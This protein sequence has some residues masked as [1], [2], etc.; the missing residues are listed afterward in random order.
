MQLH[1]ASNGQI[2]NINAMPQGIQRFIWYYYTV[3]LQ[4]KGHTKNYN[5]VT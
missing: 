4:V 2:N 5:I 3:F 1:I